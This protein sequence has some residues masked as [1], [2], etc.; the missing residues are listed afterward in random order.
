[1]PAVLAHLLH[2]R[3]PPAEIIG[4]TVTVERSLA[5]GSEVGGHDVL[6]HTVERVVRELGAEGDPVLSV[7]AENHLRDVLGLPGGDDR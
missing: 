3:G 4:R 2:H 1:M 7:D 5:T 6:G